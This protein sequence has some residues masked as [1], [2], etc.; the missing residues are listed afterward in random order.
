MEMA[1]VQCPTPAE[2]QSPMTGLEHFPE[3]APT[4]SFENLTMNQTSAAN[5][6]FTFKTELAFV[7]NSRSKKEARVL[8]RPS[9]EGTEHVLCIECA[10]LLETWLALTHEA[11]A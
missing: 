10:V 7:M 11:P 4:P 3:K 9:R 8:D 2:G 1:S 6:L 5:V